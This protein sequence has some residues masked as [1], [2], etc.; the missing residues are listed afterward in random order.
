MAFFCRNAQE[1]ALKEIA[2]QMK[3]TNEFELIREL[4]KHGAISKEIYVKSLKELMKLAK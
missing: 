2:I 3:I 4:Y 1:E